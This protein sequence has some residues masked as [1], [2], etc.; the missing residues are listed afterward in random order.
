M[1]GAALPD[2]FAQ[3]LEGFT[4]GDMEKFIAIYHPDAVHE[5]PIGPDPAPQ[6]LEGK[7]AISAYLSAVPDRA[8]FD[9]I[10]ILSVRDIAGEARSEGELVIEA[11][12]CGTFVDNGAPFE[13][14]YVWFVRYQDQQVMSFREYVGLR[15][16]ESAG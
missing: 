6:R 2:W 11:H 15:L 10:N 14:R 4:V 12:G 8:K 1:P 3:A 16:P 13:T 5:F 9:F 7:E